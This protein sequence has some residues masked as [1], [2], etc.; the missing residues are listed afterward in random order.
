MK[1]SVLLAA[2]R[3]H[4]L[5]RTHQILNIILHELF[6]AI[7]LVMLCLDGLDAVKMRYSDS[8]NSFACLD[9][10]QPIS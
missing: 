9:S 3:S 2:S 1:Y 5:A 7:Q 8:R 6:V 4:G 10:Q